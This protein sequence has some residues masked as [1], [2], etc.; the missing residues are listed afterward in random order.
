MKVPCLCHGT[1]DGG[2]GCAECVRVM[3]GV[4]GLMSSTLLV[5]NVHPDSRHSSL[6]SVADKGEVR[7]CIV[8]Q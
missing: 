3:D 6:N 2:K 8:Y 4:G 7:L 1:R 5:T